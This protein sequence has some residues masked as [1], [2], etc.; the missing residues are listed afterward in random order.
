MNNKTKLT[1]FIL[2]LFLVVVMLVGCSGS[3]EATNAYRLPLGE[4][5]ESAQIDLKLFENKEITKTIDGAEETG[6]LTYNRVVNNKNYTLTVTV[7]AKEKFDGK[8]ISFQVGQYVNGEFNKE[9]EV[10]EI[11]LTEVYAQHTYNFTLPNNAEDNK[12]NWVIKMFFGNSID[13]DVKKYRN[14][15]IIINELTLTVD[16]N[17]YNLLAEETTNPKIVK[18]IENTDVYYYNT[19]TASYD[20]NTLSLALTGKFGVWQWIVKQLGALLYWMTGIMG[21]IYWLAL[22]VFKIGRA[23]V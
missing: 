17:T 16:E 8:K 23:H 20:Q 7:E 21:G 4:S 6:Q 3:N 12:E 19:A 18:T 11:I 22:L 9:G 13:E 5:G 2:M 1:S 10:L 14:S 15:E